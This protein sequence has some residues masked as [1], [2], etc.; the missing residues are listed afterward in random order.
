MPMPVQSAP[1]GNHE[2]DDGNVSAEE[3]RWK[4][5]LT[6]DFQLQLNILVLFGFLFLVLNA[7]MEYLED[8]NVPHGALKSVVLALWVGIMMSARIPAR[9]YIWF[10]KIITRLF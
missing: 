5:L 1:A 7:N 2:P 3:W 8:N 4:Y 6:G 9:L 10:Y